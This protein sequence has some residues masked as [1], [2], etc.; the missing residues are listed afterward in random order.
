MN[1]HSQAKSVSLEPT[2]GFA[3]L[4]SAGQIMP[5]SAELLAS[6]GGSREQEYARV[7]RTLLGN[8]DG[9]VYRCSENR[10][11]N[12]EFVSAGCLR[13]TGYPAEQLL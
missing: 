3:A 11:L 5:A 12:M 1:N 13:V 8:I 2:S 4:S 10:R 6:N 7:L 9:M